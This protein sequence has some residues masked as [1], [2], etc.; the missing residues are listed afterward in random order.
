MRPI[1][2]FVAQASTDAILAELR[3]EQMQQF[4]VCSRWVRSGFGG[5]VE[6]A[7]LRHTLRWHAASPLEGRCRWHTTTFATLVLGATLVPGG[8]CGSAQRPY[9]RVRQSPGPG[10]SGSV[11]R[12]GAGRCGRARNAGGAQRPYV[13]MRRSAGPGGSGP[14]Q[15]AGA[16]AVGGSRNAGGAQGPFVR[17]RRSAGPVGSGGVLGSV[18]GRRGRAR[19]ARCATTLYAVMRLAPVDGTDPRQIEAGRSLECRVSALHLCVDEGW[20]SST[21]LRPQRCPTMWCGGADGGYSPSPAPDHSAT[22]ASCA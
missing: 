16:V 2:P 12:D 5:Q 22:R 17:M 21:A 4:A 14:C 6:D 7:A 10:G 20:R 3:N 11:S 9:T 19:N 13:R 8:F 1:R 18:T 15:A